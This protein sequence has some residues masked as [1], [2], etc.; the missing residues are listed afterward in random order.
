MAEE[1]PGW[2]RTRAP[3]GEAYEQVRAEA[4]AS[5]VH[6][7][8]DSSHC[9]NLGDCWSRGHA[10]FMLLGRRC[11]R[12]CAFCAVEHGAP[13]PVDRDEPAR[14]ARAVARLGL[15][16]AVLTSV[17]RDDLPDQGSGQFA[18]AVREL[19][20][21]SGARVE[22][23]IPDMGGDRDLLAMVAGSRPEVLGHNLET[24]RR[25]QPAVRDQR[26]GYER[27]LGVLQ[28]IKEEEPAVV[29]KSS[30]MVGLGESREEVREAMADLREVGVD[31]LAIGQYL[32]PGGGRLA[33]ARYLRPEEFEEIKDEALA[34]GFLHVAS[35]PLVRSSYRAGEAFEVGRC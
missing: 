7:V 10:T 30:L 35:G 18:A 6:T 11:T 2:L 13:E 4:R 8:C 16:H 32:R 17:A 28:V 3:G 12:R 25:L 26:A 9:P 31:L 34:M 22:L 14:V 23:L 1:K 33:V 20:R 21:Q 24:V 27:S 19:R 5:G 29:T 15:R